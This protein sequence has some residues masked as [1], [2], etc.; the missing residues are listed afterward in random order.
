MWNP[1]SEKVSNVEFQLSVFDPLVV[2]REFKRRVRSNVYG[3]T[4][5]Y[6][7]GAISLPWYKLPCNQ[8]TKYEQACDLRFKQ[9]VV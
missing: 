9:A 7:E 5:N 6:T 1:C 3:D 2:L 8:S 4:C